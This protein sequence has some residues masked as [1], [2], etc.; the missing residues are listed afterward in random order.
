[1]FIPNTYQMFWTTTP[2]KFVSRM[3]NEYDDFWTA[4]RESKIKLHN[5]DKNQAY[6]VASIVEKESNYDPEKAQ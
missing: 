2:E 1:M 5:L 6:I 3:K 4:E